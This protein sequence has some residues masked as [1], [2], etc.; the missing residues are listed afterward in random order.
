MVKRKKRVHPVVSFVTSL[1]TTKTSAPAKPREK[2]KTTTTPT[3]AESAMHTRIS[4]KVIEQ[5]DPHS[6]EM[7]WLVLVDSAATKHFCR[8]LG[9]WN[10]IAYV[11]ELNANSLRVD[12]LNE[13]GYDVTLIH[14]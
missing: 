3:K 5:Q 1:V 11:P 10:H 4:G 7:D 12:Q 9:H 2:A 8:D 14:T 13:D 6:S